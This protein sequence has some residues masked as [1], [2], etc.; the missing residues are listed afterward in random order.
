[1]KILVTGAE[2]FFAYRFIN[3]YDKLHDII[4]LGHKDLD[5]THKERVAEAIISCQPDI[6]LHCAAISDISQCDKNQKKSRDVN[7]NGTKYVALACRQT[8]AKM[9]FFSSDQ[10]Y[11]QN[12]ITVPHIETEELCPPHIYGQQKIMAEQTVMETCSQW[13]CLRLSMMYALDDIRRNEH[14]NLSASIVSAIAEEKE[15]CYP[16]YD[17]RSITDVTEV[18]QNMGRVFELPSGVYNFGSDNNDSTYETAKMIFDSFGAGHLLKKN[19]EAF[20]DAPRNIRMNTEKLKKS[21]IHLLSTKD[22][23]KKA[24]VR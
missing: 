6:V 23:I 19:E 16:V 24:Y 11:A 5:I 4:G 8:G 13:V 1:M 7:V 22:S 12:G 18:I 15:L 20:A 3:Y 14:G 2:G 10:V 17:H 9:I 21:G